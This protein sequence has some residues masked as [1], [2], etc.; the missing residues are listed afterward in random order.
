MYEVGDAEKEISVK[1]S[2]RHC[3]GGFDSV[4]GI[5]LFPY[6]STREQLRAMCKTAFGALRPGNQVFHHEANNG[7]SFGSTVCVSVKQSQQSVGPVVI[8]HYRPYA[9]L[10][11]SLHWILLQ[12][13]VSL[14]PQLC[15]EVVSK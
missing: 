7:C 5:F 12:A 2:R 1:I 11:A 14:G 4:V 3:E 9:F 15:T 13:D 6:A 8:D 10:N